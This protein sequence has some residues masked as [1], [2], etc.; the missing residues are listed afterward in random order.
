[1]DCVKMRDAALENIKGGM[2]PR[3]A[4]LR[5]LDDTLD[6]DQRHFVLIHPPRIPTVKKMMELIPILDRPDIDKFRETLIWELVTM[7]FYAPRAKKPQIILSEGRVAGSQYIFEF[8]VSDL[9]KP[10]EN[11]INWHGQDT[12]QWCYAGCIMVQDGKIST[13]H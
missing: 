8:A 13:H 3:V 6:K 11:K 10:V 5:L 2:E 7:A 12:S 1:M 9:E 4:L